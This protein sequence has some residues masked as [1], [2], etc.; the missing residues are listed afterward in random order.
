MRLVLRLLRSLVHS[1]VARPGGRQG[2]GARARQVPAEPRVEALS[3]CRPPV[4]RR[5]AQ[6]QAQWRRSPACAPA[7]APP[8]VGHR[9]LRGGMGCTPLR[10]AIAAL[11]LAL[12]CASPSGLD[13]LLL[14]A[15]RVGNLDAA[16]LAA[17]R[18]ANVSAVDSRGFGVVSLALQGWQSATERF[19]GRGWN[20]TAHSDMVTMLVESGLGDVRGSVLAG[21]GCPVVEAVHFRL[22]RAAQQIARA[23]GDPEHL[24]RCLVPENVWGQTVLHAAATSHASGLTRLLLRLPQRW[25]GSSAEAES[26]GALLDLDMAAAS[27]T[28]RDVPGG[29]GEAIPVVRFGD[30]ARAASGRDLEWLLR[31]GK[32]AG[33]DMGAWALHRDSLGRTAADI[34][35]AEGRLSAAGALLH[36]AGALQAGE[37]AACQRAARAAGF[38][39]SLGLGCGAGSDGPCT[40]VSG[41]GSPLPSVSGLAGQGALLRLR[42][43]LDMARQ[44]GEETCKDSGCSRKLER[45][46]AGLDQELAVAVVAVL[47]AFPDMLEAPL[48]PRRDWTRDEALA[49]VE[50]C[51]LNASSPCLLRQR[52]GARPSAPGGLWQGRKRSLARQIRASKRLAAENEAN[53]SHPRPLVSKKRLIEA[54]GSMTV[55]VADIPYGSTYGSQRASRERLSTFVRDSMGKRAATGGA[56]DGKAPVSASSP[57]LYVFQALPPGRAERV[58]PVPALPSR[59][60]SHISQLIVGPAGTGAIPH[61]HGPAVNGLAVGRKLWVVTRPGCSEFS[62]EHAR[63]WVFRAAWMSA[64]A[65]SPLCVPWIFVQEAGD[66]AVI[67]RHFGHAVLNL[68]DT[69]AVAF[70]QP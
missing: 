63:S 69:V 47:E 2:L 67:P 48:S 1:T 43:Q 35:C 32:L 26:L 19:P 51:M 10:L 41:E 9:C 70:E 34:A 45:G 52:F 8:A 39:S 28:Y 18:G 46:W 64:A 15:V 30:I 24:K 40:A 57:P 66:V 27:P 49:T 37:A 62:P 14:R 56:H 21:S 61:Y 6:R 7:S 20:S 36:A 25:A 60:R 11:A 50:A 23:M 58:V 68:Q 4:R 33:A 53:T 29:A 54:A 59:M 12:C 5:R 31:A 17:Q 16:R 55:A 13:S 42:A 44:E 22:L 3:G 65:E 38:D